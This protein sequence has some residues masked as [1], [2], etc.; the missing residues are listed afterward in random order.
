MKLKHEES[1]N[2]D[3][4]KQ[5]QKEL[6]VYKKYGG[7]FLWGDAQYTE[8]A[9]R[10]QSANFTYGVANTSTDGTWRTTLEDEVKGKRP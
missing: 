10:V 7:D 8:L 6:N 3:F 1:T 9:E 2:E 5:V 4:L